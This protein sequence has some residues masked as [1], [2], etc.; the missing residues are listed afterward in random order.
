MKN[1][2]LLFLAAC[3][4]SGCNHFVN[5]KTVFD[6]T[7]TPKSPDYADLRNWAAHPDLSDPADQTPC[8]LVKNEEATAQVD[9]FFIHPTTYTGA[10]KNQTEWNGGLN[11]P[12]LNKKTD[13]GSI[14]FQASIFNGAGRVFAPRYRQAHLH[15]FYTKDKQSA[16]KALDVAYQDILAAFDY[17]L[18]HWNN[19][20]PFVIAGHSQGGLHTMLLVHDRI[21]GQAL[22]KQL[23][24][25]YMVGWPVQS[26]YFKQFKPCES[27]DQTDCYCTWRTWERKFGKK[28]FAAINS[29]VVCTNPL[30]WST[31]NGSYAPK[32][33]NI[34]G[35]V[36]PFCAIYPNMTDAEVLNGFLLCSKPKFPG[37]IFFR[38]KNYHPGDLNLYY[39]NVRQ[40][41]QA[42]AQAYLKK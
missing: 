11:D 38:T 4:G 14:L 23:V 24:A 35:V 29:N 3:L 19:G 18:K 22:E 5:P 6:P 15:A 8:P 26:D 31:K 16:K 7:K 13:E 34:G 25:A 30:T 2:L 41:V 17:Y 39:M 20:R 10:D 32:S 1:A 28:K 21:E 27:P 37:S 42:R 12:A 9:V 40:N 33:A 36:R